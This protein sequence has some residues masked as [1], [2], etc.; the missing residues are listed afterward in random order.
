VIEKYP[1]GNKVPSALLKQGHAFLALGDKVNSRLIF[2]ELIR[3][4]PNTAEAKAASEKLKE[5]R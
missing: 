3:K 5:I 2:E 4:Y 1:K